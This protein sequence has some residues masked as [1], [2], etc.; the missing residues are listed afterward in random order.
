MKDIDWKFLWNDVRF[1][2]FS[3]D[4]SIF[5]T[6]WNLFRRPG[7]FIREFLAG[8][9]VRRFSPVR[10]TLTL[11]AVYAGL[12]TTAKV[13]LVVSTAE[14]TSIGLSAERIQEWV[15]AHYGLVEIALVPILGLSAYLAFRKG[16]LSLA[17]HFGA[18]AYIGCQ[19]IVLKILFL[20]VALLSGQRVPILLSTL[21]TAATCGM[22]AFTYWQ[23]F[24]S[25]GGWTRTMGTLLT[26]L[27]FGSGFFG[28]VA[29]GLWLY[30]Q[31]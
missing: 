10:L 2:F 19:N 28:V 14:A 3:Y 12:L 26:L 31:L 29:L 16:G 13:K 22:V 15:L 30:T 27:L 5:L 18:A 24:P 25:L 1:L 11:A 23:L 17:A 21:P 4:A 6:L 9:R 7:V 8:K 20:L